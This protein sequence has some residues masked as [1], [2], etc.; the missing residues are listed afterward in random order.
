[1]FDTPQLLLG[2]DCPSTA[3]WGQVASTLHR[4][5]DGCETQL[6]QVPV[7]QHSTFQMWIWSSEAS[8]GVVYYF[9]ETWCNVAKQSFFRG[10][11]H[12]P[13]VSRG[14]V[15]A[16]VRGSTVWAPRFHFLKRSPSSGLETHFATLSG[17]PI[18]SHQTQRQTTS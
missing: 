7:I 15:E 14:S 6:R 10:H 17:T 13:A 8:A 3:V 4:Q 2:E 12:S 5:E 1:M 11:G 18:L 16:T 9:G